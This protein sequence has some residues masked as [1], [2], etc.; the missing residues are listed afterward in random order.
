M[1]S[2]NL[3][4]SDHLDLWIKFG[5]MYCVD[6]KMDTVM[7]FKRWSFVVDGEIFE[8]DP[9]KIDIIK[10]QNRGEVWRQVTMV[11]IFLDLNNLS[12]NLGSWETARLP[13]P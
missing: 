1:P 12:I 7:W 5:F 9:L 11:A 10:G 13:L 3:R 2:R 4:W 6:N 8:F